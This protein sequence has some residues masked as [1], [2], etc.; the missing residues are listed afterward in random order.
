MAIMRSE[1]PP[2]LGVTNVM[3]K[4]DDEELE[5]ILYNIERCGQAAML[6]IIGFHLQKTCGLLNRD[7]IPSLFTTQ[8][9]QINFPI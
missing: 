7:S 6:I 4:Q 9:L 8:A 1:I 3:G 2:D 5:A